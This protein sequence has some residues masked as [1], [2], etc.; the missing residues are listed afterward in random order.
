MTKNGVKIYLRVFSFSIHKWEYFSYDTVN[1]YNSLF[2]F[3][4]GGVR[5]AQLPSLEREQQLC[6][7]KNKSAG[8]WTASLTHFIYKYSAKK[9]DRRSSSLSRSFWAYIYIEIRRPQNIKFLIVFTQKVVFGRKKQKHM[10]L[11]Q[12]LVVCFLKSSF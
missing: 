3:V 6:I 4:L 8:S 11:V 10:L 9:A 12:A 7:T 2:F 5:N 1:V